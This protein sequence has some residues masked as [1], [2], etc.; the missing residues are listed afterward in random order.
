MSDFSAQNSLALFAGNANIAGLTAED[1][2]ISVTFSASPVSL[3]TVYRTI[4]RQWLPPKFSRVLDESKFGG[5]VEVVQATVTGSSRLDVGLSAVGTFRIENG[6]LKRK[7]KWPEIRDIRGTI[8]VQPDRIKFSN[9]TGVYD[10]LPVR[11]ANGRLLFKETGPWMEVEVQGV[12]PGQR[13][14][15][16]L[17]E[18]SSVD[19]TFRRLS[20]WKVEGGTG[21]LT[22]RFAGLIQDVHGLSFEQG[23]YV[24]KN[25][26]ITIPEFENPGFQGSRSV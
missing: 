9:F 12:V 15:K 6:F 10:S 24:A 20:T 4:P 7:Q 14:L 5:M 26:Q 11:A 23:E 22:L 3:E 21:L 13:V 18:I 8:V 2:T 1:P 19:Q 17:H 25:L 16:V